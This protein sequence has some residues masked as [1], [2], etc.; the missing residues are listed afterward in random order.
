MKKS[1]GIRWETIAFKGN[2]AAVVGRLKDMGA[3]PES[4]YNYCHSMGAR[5]GMQRIEKLF[6]QP[7]QTVCNSWVLTL[8][9]Y[10]LHLQI[11]AA[12]EALK[13]ISLSLQTQ[14]ES[15]NSK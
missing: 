13:I 5:I 15:G 1:K 11:K 9:G 12:A 8:N 3:T 2:K 6:A 14:T 10:R 7:E 4:L